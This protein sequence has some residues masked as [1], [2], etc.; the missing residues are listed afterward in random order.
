M[1]PT[2]RITTPYMTKYERARVLGTRALQI[3]YIRKHRRWT[4]LGRWEPGAEDRTGVGRVW[5]GWVVLGGVGW[6][7][8]PMNMRMSHWSRAIIRLRDEACRMGSASVP[9]IASSSM[10]CARHRRS[11]RVGEGTGVAQR[12]EAGGGWADS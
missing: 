3:R 11:K 12:A 2:E 9:A 1:P 5:G 7:A 6:R 8:W 10:S 4:A